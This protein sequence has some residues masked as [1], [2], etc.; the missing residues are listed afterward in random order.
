MT[1][2]HGPWTIKSTEQIYRDPF[3]E[4]T[5]DQVIRPD[6]NDG[7]HV[8]VKIK[9]GVCVVAVDDDRNIHLTKE[10]HYAVGRDS[11]EAV[12]GGV[13]PNE[14][15]DL[16]AKRELQE[17]LGLEAKAW[18]FLTTVDPFTTCLA[19]PTRL[20]LATD[21]SN[22]ETNPEGTEQ[23]EHVIMPL[24]KAAAMVADGEITHAPSCVAILLTEA[25]I[26]KSI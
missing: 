12:S 19:S 1:K 8:V 5:L 17:E 20:Y 9:P 4:L 23:I 25:A 16:T 24:S 22:V 3:V 14:D 2:P 11:I 10:F 13:E 6:G 18:K 15:A 7:Q 21:L 26:P